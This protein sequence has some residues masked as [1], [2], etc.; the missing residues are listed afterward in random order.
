M[1]PEQELLAGPGEEVAQYAAL[2]LV[3]QGLGR[4]RQGVVSDD[5]AVDKGDRALALLGVGGEVV[6]QEQ[7]EGRAGQA[8][9]RRVA[10][11]AAPGLDDAGDREEAE[12]L[13]QRR[14][15]QVIG[16]VAGAGGAQRGPQVVEG[17]LGP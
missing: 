4:D 1:R 10:A 5:L 16:R 2:H 14:V 9:R 3:A 13:A 11:R 6:A 8:R 17:G 12:G 15:G 7:P